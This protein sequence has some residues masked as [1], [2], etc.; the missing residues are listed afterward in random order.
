MPKGRESQEALDVVDVGLSEVPKNNRQ[1]R[2]DTLKA[3]YPELYQYAEK[4]AFRFNVGEE[5][6]ALLIEKFIADARVIA[7]EESRAE[8]LHKQYLAAK[9]RSS[10]A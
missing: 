7:D 6:T 5:E 2:L 8:K 9:D 3:R 1:A 4:F 10:A